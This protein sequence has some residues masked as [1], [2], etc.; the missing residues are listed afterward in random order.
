MINKKYQNLSYNKKSGIKLE[1]RQKSP[2]PFKGARYLG[3]FINGNQMSSYPRFDQNLAASILS[4]Y[5]GTTP[6]FL[7]KI[8]SVC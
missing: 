3:D 2:H 4:S 1:S 8:I 7:W 6:I 5:L